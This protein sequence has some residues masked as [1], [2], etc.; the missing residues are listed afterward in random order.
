MNI[1]VLDGNLINLKDYEMDAASARKRNA[2]LQHDKD[3]PKIQQGRDHFEQQAELG[4][5]YE[6][7]FKQI[8]L[9]LGLTRPDY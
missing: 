2:R 1:E 5:K 7:D 4:G 6:S 3:R 8:W 9:V